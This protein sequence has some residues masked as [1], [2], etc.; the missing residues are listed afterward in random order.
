MPQIQGKCLCESVK[1][2]AQPV[3]EELGVCHCSMCRKWSAGPLMV[4]D[5]GT[6][7]T[8][9]GEQNVSV[10]HSSDWGERGFCTKCGTNL[11]WRMRSTGQTM[12]STELFDGVPFKFDHQIFIDEKPDY[13]NFSNETHNMT[14]A[15][16]IESFN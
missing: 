12:V 3:K 14:G 16:V 10:F 9:E 4:V 2:I 15:E 7:V 6:D 13:Y 5:C 11:F 8:F 1:I